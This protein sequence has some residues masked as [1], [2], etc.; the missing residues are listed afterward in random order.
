MNH[1]A[2]LYEHVNKLYDSFENS[3]SLLDEIFPTN[4]QYE[5]HKGRN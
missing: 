1:Y 2:N 5:R 4:K 3:M